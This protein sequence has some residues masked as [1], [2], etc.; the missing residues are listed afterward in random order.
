MRKFEGLLPEGLEEQN[1][2]YICIQDG[3]EMIF[4]EPG[5]FLMGGRYIQI[6]KGYFIDKYPILNSEYAQFAKSK[7][8]SP[9]QLG[10][11]PDLPVVGV[12]WYEA[13]AY[14]RWAGKHLPTEAMWTKA[15]SQR[16]LDGIEFFDGFWEWSCDWVELK[17]RKVGQEKI[18]LHQA[19]MPFE[20][21]RSKLKPHIRAILLGFRCSKILKGG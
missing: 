10:G 7:G 6:S 3:K 9:N 17:D 1:G 2:K 18:I 15:E 11:A 21:N 4:I 20:S 12:S 5:R 8:F 13:D 16:F 14:A 19:K